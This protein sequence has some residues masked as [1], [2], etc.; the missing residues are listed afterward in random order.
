MRKGTAEYVVKL[1]EQPVCVRFCVRTQKRT[2]LTL[3]KVWG[4][5]HQ[6]FYI[7]FLLSSRFGEQGTQGEEQ[8]L[9]LERMREMYIFLHT[10]L[11]H[12]NFL[13]G[14]SFIIKELKN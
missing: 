4:A 14:V 7:V 9:S 13:K 6:N 12:S 10:F 11:W 1:Y 3:T 5:M 2:H 8:H